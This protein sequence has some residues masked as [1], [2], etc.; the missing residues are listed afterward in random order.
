M[1]MRAII[2]F[3]SI[4]VMLTS[5]CSQSKKDERKNSPVESSKEQSGSSENIVARVNS[6]PIYEMELRDRNLDDI[7][8]DQILYHDAIRQGLDKDGS[9]EDRVNR[10][11]RN[12]IVSTLVKSDEDALRRVAPKSRRA[13]Q[14]Y[15]Q[16][17][18]KQREDGSNKQEPN[19]QE[20]KHAIPKDF[21][22]EEAVRVGLDKDEKILENVNK[23]RRNLLTY[24]YKEKLVPDLSALDDIRQE[25][26]NKFY[27]DNIRK[28]TKYDL[29]F[30]SLK[31]KGLA[32]EIHQRA[33]AGEDLK[34]LYP[35]YNAKYPDAKIIHRKLF[36]NTK[37]AN[38]LVGKE[39]G[40]VTD[41]LNEGDNYKILKLKKIRIEPVS[42]VQ[43]QI[44]NYLL[45]R[46]KDKKLREIA[47]SIAQ[48]NNIDVEIY[49]EDQKK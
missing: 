14:S 25:D 18:Q 12:L 13:V 3:L 36:Y 1:K 48:K 2:Y 15:L 8:A 5:G 22:Y 45:I 44:K 21:L 49:M 4:L 19:S 27:E 28:F 16:K 9:I 41:I 6:R 47:N 39:V 30:L 17:S 26:I 35:E 38:L 32:D 34:N 42:R 11:K 43:G 29:E 46:K 23:F 24:E 40:T 37:Y 7:I 31:D 20:S 10:Y 33:M